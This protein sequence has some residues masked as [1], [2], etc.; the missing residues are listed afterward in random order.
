M[1]ESHN[2]SA[3]SDYSRWPWPQAPMITEIH[4]GPMTIDLDAILR[5]RGLRIPRFITSAM[6]RIV[7]QD[8]LN[9]ILDG[10]FPRAGWAF[11]HHVLSH[12]GLRVRIKGLDA[13]SPDGRYLFA[14]N[15]PLGGLDGV[16]LI[17]ILGRRFGDS[18]MA[19]I[20]NDMLMNVR[21]LSSVFVAVNK[22]GRQRRDVARA[23]EEAYAGPRHVMIFPAGLVSRLGHNGLVRDLEWQKSFITRAAASGRLIIP[24]RFSASNSPGFYRKARLR[25]RLGLRFNFE[26]ILLPS[27]IF[28]TRGATFSVE[29]LPP[30]SPALLLRDSSPRQAAARLR[31]LIY[32]H[33]L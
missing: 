29:F 13:L 25:K 2:L 27:E 16:T 8:G 30:V 14:S 3:W 23:L 4:P 28:R 20:V 31:D 15:H 1:H 17:A 32:G 12:L 10:A 19:F 9:Q 6:A 11:A 33:P 26:Q 21:P 24:V 7:R 18:R 5:S 22:Y